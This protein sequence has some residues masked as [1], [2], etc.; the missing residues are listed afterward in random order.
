MLTC[1]SLSAAKA[2]RTHWQ[3]RCLRQAMLL[4]SL[5]AEARRVCLDTRAEHAAARGYGR[6]LAPA[7]RATPRAELESKLEPEPRPVLIS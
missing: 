2:K 4:A 5:A 7:A 6:R 3:S 1:S